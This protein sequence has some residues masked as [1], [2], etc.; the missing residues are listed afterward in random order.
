MS[1]APLRESLLGAVRAEA[2]STRLRDEEAG[3][4]AL[5]V[6]REQ[7]ERLVEDARLAGERAAG[8][9]AARAHAAAAR[10]ARESRLDVERSLVD[11]LRAR[12]LD[13]TRA[14]RSDPRYGKLLDRL[15]KRALAQLGP[16]AELV[17]DP[18]ET[19]GL[20]ARAGRRS[21][22]Y[23]LP[24]LVDRAIEE[25]GASLEELWR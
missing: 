13:A 6:A 8:R 23:T 2:E 15:A 20:R 1:L 12:V 16:E 25:L 3:G 22:D 5:A 9:E 14:A 18:P 24:V 21:V 7:A 19:G 17:R 10:Q 11:E 4:A